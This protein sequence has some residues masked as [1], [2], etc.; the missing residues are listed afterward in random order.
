MSIVSDAIRSYNPTAPNFSNEAALSNSVSHSISSVGDIFN[1]I[2]LQRIQQ[3]EFDREQMFKQAELAEKARQFGLNLLESQADRASRERISE[4]E[5]KGRERVAN[6][7]YE[8][9]KKLEELKWGRQAKQAKVI[10][11]TL[12]QFTG[13]PQ[14]KVYKAYTDELNAN[15]DYQT[16]GTTERDIN[17]NISN[18][19]EQQRTAAKNLLTTYQQT[20]EDLQLEQK[21]LKR[22]Q[23]LQK[24]GYFSNYD[25][26]GNVVPYVS[27]GKEIMY[28]FFGNPIEIGNYT[29][30]E[31]LENEARKL[32]EK[33]KEYRKGFQFDKQ[34]NPII[35]NRTDPITLE[36]F[37][38]DAANIKKLKE[39]EQLQNELMTN[40]KINKKRIEGTIWDNY[41]DKF[42]NLNPG[43]TEI[44][45]TNELGEAIY[46]DG[47]NNETTSP[48]TITK[49]E[50]GNV[51]E[52]PNK[53]VYSKV[54]DVAKRQLILA[55]ALGEA[56]FPPLSLGEDLNAQLL[57]AS[58]KGQYEVAASQARSQN[59][60]KQEKQKIL[61]KDA[62]TNGNAP[63]D[64]II[65]QNRKKPIEDSD[66]RQA[67]NSFGRTIENFVKSNSL[68]MSK[69]SLALAL[70]DYLLQ[71]A[72]FLSSWLPTS[73]DSRRASI[74]SIGKGRTISEIQKMKDRIEELQSGGS[75]INLQ[76]IRML[77]EGDE[78]DKELAEILKL[79]LTG[80]L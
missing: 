15:K 8:N 33:N 52:I 49:D 57:L 37:R 60:W 67:I 30:N 5:I 12:E 32:Y 45:K 54:P 74:T 39:Q 64:V 63:Y 13:V 1:K 16:L 73:G 19:Q 23:D 10:A 68:K 58:Q 61:L 29:R 3:E 2:A 51:V 26:Q 71:D 53:I 42:N 72:G 22:L 56:G 21:N 31:M 50:K 79:T 36:Q 55:Q 65:Q 70:D 34:G 24:Q 59:A 69:K 78:Y 20:P 43:F 77:E 80:D 66:T 4:N 46:K 27:P 17:R 44:P 11:D 48:I 76:F 75:K 25:D 7:N 62:L 47:D 41:K 18:L 6:Q 9:Q 14:D 35:D 28:D 40:V 38:K